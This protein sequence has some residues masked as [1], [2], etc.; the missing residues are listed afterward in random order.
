MS[1][2][3]AGDLDLAFERNGWTAEDVK[4][5]STGEI[6]ADVLRV[7]KGKF[8]FTAGVD[9][10]DCDT[11]VFVP[12]GWGVLPDSEQLPN[13]VRGLVKFDPTKIELY[14]VDDQK[15]GGLIGG[16]EIRKGLE[17]KSVYTAHILDYLLEPRN[18]HRIPEEWKAKLA[19][20][21]GTIYRIDGH[22]YVRSLY[23]GG[24][25]W[26]CGRYWLGNSW[27]YRGSAVVSA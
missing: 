12:D 17:T 26:Y 23:W 2:R 7:R 24:S 3:Q 21:W 11:Q 8:V 14:L 15:S 19:F 6:L 5:L 25:R 27:D 4:W 13:R 1:V 9:L 10:I 20:F 22:L 16:H 18:Q